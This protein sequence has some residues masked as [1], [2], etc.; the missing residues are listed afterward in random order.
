M[1]PLLPAVKLSRLLLWIQI[2]SFFPY[3]SL[4]FP[5]EHHRPGHPPPLQPAM[6]AGYH[7]KCP[8]VFLPNASSM[9]F[10]VW[11]LSP[12]SSS[13]ILHLMEMNVSGHSSR[14]RKGDGSLGHVPLA[15]GSAGSCP[16]WGSPL[17]TDCVPLCA[18]SP[19]P[20]PIT[21]HQ[22]R[23]WCQKSEPGWEERKEMRKEIRTE[24]RMGSDGRERMSWWQ[25]E[26]ETSAP[27]RSQ[28]VRGN[29]QESCCPGSLILQN[30]WQGKWKLGWRVA[31]VARWQ[32]GRTLLFSHSAVTS[33]SCHT[34]SGGLGKGKHQATGLNPLLIIRN[35]S[36]TWSSLQLIVECVRYS[37]V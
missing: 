15:G 33:D 9:F 3:D 20:L 21:A 34:E 12:L 22:R 27:S 24:A 36:G 28:N 26:K 37:L 35:V 4:P 5:K 1:W 25:W 6:I 13:F 11:T 30:Q 16:G 19:I 18:S 23:W 8:R 14:Q 17:F 2:I 31:A 7:S 29:R 32:D 10:H